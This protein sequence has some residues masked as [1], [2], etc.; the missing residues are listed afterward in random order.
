[1]NKEGTFYMDEAVKGG[2]LSRY[3]ILETEPDE[4]Y[5]G[6]T[7]LASLVCATPIAAL[8]I[9]T[10][11]RQWLMSAVGLSSREV[12][13]EAGFGVHTATGSASAGCERRAD[14]ISDAHAD[15][16][17]AGN[18]WVVGEPHIRFYAGV[19][20]VMSDGYLLGVLF[21][22]DTNPRHD[23][24][25]VGPV[26]ADLAVQIVHLLE[27]KIR[28]LDLESALVHQRKEDEDLKAQ[29]DQIHNY[30]RELQVHA[31][32]LEAINARLEALAKLDG[33]TGLKN[34]RAFQERLEFEFQR[35]V[36][37]SMPLSLLLLDVDSFKQFND[38]FGHL[39]GDEVLNTVAQVLQ[40]NAR[41]VDLV[42]R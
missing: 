13:R 31:V 26:L 39:A 11:D 20:I 32:R 41:G 19:P 33:M 10:P 15:S 2:A 16:E 28:A 27:N 37:Y 17:L 23:T 8:S 25:H 3:A 36:R 14:V 42:S 7:R 29:V 30:S 34:H 40:E 12:P 9:I 22:A 18:E 4:P 24:P 5:A 1:V 38:T 35:A 21:V 6:I